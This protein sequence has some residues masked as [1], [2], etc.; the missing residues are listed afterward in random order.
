[1]RESNNTIKQ[2]QI[3][4]ENILFGK[5]LYR[6]VTSSL[7]KEKKNRLL[8]TL[9][10]STGQGQFFDIIRIAVQCHTSTITT[11]PTSAMKTAIPIFIIVLVESEI[12]VLHRLLPS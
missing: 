11:T 7:N 10:D 4:R 2:E 9:T 5:K 12:V 1:V 3:A 8:K 6:C